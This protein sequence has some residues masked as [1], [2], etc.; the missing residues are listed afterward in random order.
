MRSAALLLFF[1]TVWSPAWEGPNNTTPR[2]IVTDADVQL[3]LDIWQKKLGLDDWKIHFL[4]VRQTELKP[5]TSGNVRW[6]LDKCVAV[7]K[8]LDPRDYALPSE[9]IP[10]DIEFTIVHE[11]VHLTLAPTLSPLQRNDANRQDEESAVNN[12]ATA[13]FKLHSVAKIKSR[14]DNGEFIT[15]S[16]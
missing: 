5:K 9:Q 13:L 15:T 16:K 14:G 8:V 3:W 12:I 11:L 10:A 4:I 1:A 7:I 6:D 2:P